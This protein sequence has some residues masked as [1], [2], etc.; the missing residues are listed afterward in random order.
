MNEQKPS[1]K[2]K[3]LVKPPYSYIALIAMAINR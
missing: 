1:M 3:D 2:N